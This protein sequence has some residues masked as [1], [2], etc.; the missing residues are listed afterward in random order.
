MICL[1]SQSRYLA[2]LRFKNFLHISEFRAIFIIF[3]FISFIFWPCQVTCE[4]LV[5]YQGSNPCPLKWQYGVLTTGP[6]GKTPRLSLKDILM[7][8]LVFSVGPNVDD[9]RGCDQPSGHFPSSR[10]FRIRA[11]ETDSS[12]AF[13][14]N[15]DS[16]PQRLLSQ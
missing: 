5:P 8:L 12:L 4:I 14:R 9:W 10:T 6:P 7:L 13:L 2:E 16:A 15:S 3:Y 1:K 11:L